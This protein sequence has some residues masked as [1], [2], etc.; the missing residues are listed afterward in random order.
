MKYDLRVLVGRLDRQGQRAFESAAL[1]AKGAGHEDLTTAHFLKALLR[2]PNSRCVSLLTAAGL[3]D[4]KVIAELDERLAILPESKI[5][6]LPTPSVELQR[7]LQEALVLA[8]EM[9]SDDESTPTIDALALLRALTEVDAIRRTTRQSCPVLLGIQLPSTAASLS[10]TTSRKTESSDANHVLAVADDPPVQRALRTPA[11]DRYTIDLTARARAGLIDPIVGRESEIRQVVDILARR[12]QNNPILLGEAGVG[13][14]AVVEGFA[15][16]I[17]TG[18]VPPLLQD[19]VV[20]SLDVGALRA[21]A[22][23]RGDFEDRLKSVIREVVAS[24]RPIVLFVDEAHTLLGSGAGDAADLLKPALAR[25]ELRTVAATTWAEYKRHIERDPALERRFQPIKVAEP[26]T[27]NAI[28]MLRALAPHLQNHHGVRVLDE[29][30]VDAVKLS[31]RYVSGRRLPDKAIAVL[32]TASA[33]VTVART[34]TPSVIVEQKRLMER[35]EAEIAMLSRERALGRDHQERID[36]LYAR[37]DHAEAQCFRLESRWAAELDLIQQIDALAVPDGGDDAEVVAGKPLAA[38][39]ERDRLEQQ[40]RELQGESPLIP[41][42]V[43]SNVVAQVISDWTG[44]PI[45]R[46]HTDQIHAVLSLAEQMGDHIIGQSG[47]IDLITRRIRTSRVGLSNPKRPVGVFLLLGPTG[48]GKTQTARVLAELLYGGERNLVTI[49][50]SEY[51]E[52]HSVSGLKGAPPGYVGYG[53][54]GVLTEAVRRNPYSLVLLDEVE[55]AHPDVLELF[56]SVFDTGELDDAEGLSV[57]FRN[58]LFL[59][60]SNLG[61]HVILD[62]KRATTAELAE[63]VRPHLERHFSAAL[64][65]RMTAVPY[66]ALVEADFKKITQQALGQVVSRVMESQGIRATYDDA[67]VDEIV[68]RCLIRGNGARSVEHV[69][70]HEILPEMSSVALDWMARGEVCRWIH[71]SV[72]KPHSFSISGYAETP[73][74]VGTGGAEQ[75]DPLSSDPELDVTESKD[76]PIDMLPLWRS[77]RLTDVFR[78]NGLLLSDK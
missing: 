46:M 67:T 47:A 26:D 64:L 77:R 6:Q 57:N 44:V 13:K 75:K 8:S 63:L 3:E 54:G 18:D 17:A 9:L 34:S 62:S 31:Q 15:A 7:L 69:L 23:L 25:G 12:R 76:S 2:V 20:R 30:L 40:L 36:A 66:S 52:A 48:V 5:G 56:Y 41:L 45:S 24:P 19:V 21:G 42:S 33:R 35:L 29:A 55:K 59:L 49:N 60:T 58:C 51:Q 38:L 65:A 72:E 78:R 73:S 14:T 68:R 27:P 61:S 50:M 70:S 16:R 4:Y 53:K 10:E 28:A 43:D 22:T 74:V 37:L 11:L 39:P 71:V 1:L 32:D